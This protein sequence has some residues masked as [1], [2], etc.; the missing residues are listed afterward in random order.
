MKKTTRQATSKLFVDNLPKKKS[1]EV[2][3]IN[4]VC[5]VCKEAFDPDTEITWLPCS[6]Y[7][8]VECITPWITS[9]NINSLD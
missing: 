6:H 8:H 9:V 7:Y 4:N 1:E 5:E 2:S 3:L